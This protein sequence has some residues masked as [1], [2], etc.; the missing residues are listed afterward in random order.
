MFKWMEDSHFL[1][2]DQKLAMIKLNEEGM[3][4]PKIAES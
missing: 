4:K 2:L 1:I 3:S